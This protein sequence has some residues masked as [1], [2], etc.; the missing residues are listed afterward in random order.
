[1]NKCEKRDDCVLIED[2]GTSTCEKAGPVEPP[3]FE[4]KSCTSSA[5]C[6]EPLG[7]FKRFEYDGQGSVFYSVPNGYCA[8]SETSTDGVCKETVQSCDGTCP[9]GINNHPARCLGGNFGSV[10][11]FSCIWSPTSS[12]C[13][14]TFG[15]SRCQKDGTSPV[16]TNV[17]TTCNNDHSQV[18]QFCKYGTGC[19]GLYSTCDNG[20]C[21]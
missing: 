4:E 12:F 6:V 7:T 3:P 16:C 18:D 13:A 19:N 11:L 21:V 9:T 15:L 14:E 17:D 8:K 20:K 1:M 5:D 2:G 10:C